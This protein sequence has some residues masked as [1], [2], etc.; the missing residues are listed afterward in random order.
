MK[1]HESERPQTPKFC[2]ASFTRRS[3][4]LKK[5]AFTYLRK[6]KC[7]SQRLL[8]SRGLHILLRTCS[9][10]PPVTASR[11]ISSSKFIRH[12]KVNT[13]NA[14]VIHEEMQYTSTECF[15]KA[16]VHGYRGSRIRQ[17]DITT[18]LPLTN[19]QN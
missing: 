9:Y 14:S 19:R 15:Y 16:T 13:K 7:L 12:Q 6:F 1:T 4:P 10:L 17:H 5:F 18:A 8:P 11:L 2:P 3:S